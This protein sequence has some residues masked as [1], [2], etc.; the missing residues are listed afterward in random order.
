MR[1]DVTCV[2]GQQ[3]AVA[4]A[5]LGRVVACP[6]C[7]R[8]LIPLAVTPAA[9]EGT[10]AD[11]GGGGTAAAGAEPTRRC[12]MCGE[13]IL[14]V[15]R[16]CR[17]CGE[18]VGKADGTAPGGEGGAA[19][20]GE[21]PPVYVLSVSQ[22]DNFFRYLICITIVTVAGVVLFGPFPWGPMVAPHAG[23]AFAVLAGVVGLVMLFFYASARH[24]RCI[25]RPDRVETETGVLSKHIESLEMHR[26]VDVSLRQ[27]LLQR[28]LGIGTVVI[29]ST[30]PTTPQLELYMI[31]KARKVYRYV[32]EQ[33]P[34]A[35]QARGV[36][37][38]ER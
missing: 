7:N 21:A 5:G 3:F 22:W 6:G 38:V 2:C 11:S 23:V 28:V 34:R 29:R 12:P 4:P 20:A 14:A 8:A 25:I 36:V 30:D 13:R 9:G 37:Q 19:K 35:D 33:A 27:N 1:Y 10:G 26:I 17:F 18:M 24:A 32:Q 15:A 31:P 16:K